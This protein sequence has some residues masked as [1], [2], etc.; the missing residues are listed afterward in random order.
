M[1]LSHRGFLLFLF[2]ALLSL[3]P[4]CSSS[5]S[6][7]IAMAIGQR[8]KVGKLSY[9]VTEAL[10]L[11]EVPGGKQP[12]KNRILQLRLMVTNSGSEE[13]SIPFLR[14]IDSKG[15]ETVEVR[16][17]EGNSSW[18]GSLR[19]LQP[20]ITEEGNVYFDVTVGGYKLEVVD[21]SVADDE[22]VAH[23]EIPA[24]LAPPP[25]SP[26]PAGN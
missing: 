14:L 5:K 24:S 3:A 6:R 2:S 22:K 19:R 17:I 18:L 26:G 7:I 1:M 8:V 23:I 4:S 16:E 10:W 25:T 15:N 11:T 9:Q 12:A 20:A 21:N 13:A